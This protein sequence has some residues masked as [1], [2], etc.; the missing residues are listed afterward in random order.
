M[1][2]DI[3]LRA[4]ESQNDETF[5]TYVMKSKIDGT[6]LNESSFLIELDADQ[7]DDLAVYY[8]SESA[9]WN[10]KAERYKG[11]SIVQKES[12]FNLYKKYYSLYKCIRD[13]QGKKFA[14]GIE[15]IV[16]N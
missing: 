5:K 1:S 16:E 7:M 8:L 4:E 15:I 12:Y 10:A 6:K 14:E 3:F 2:A 11:D 13:I 9:K